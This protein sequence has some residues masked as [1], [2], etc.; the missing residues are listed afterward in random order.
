M[1][2]ATLFWW[3][4]PVDAACAV[5]FLPCRHLRAFRP[6]RFKVTLEAVLVLEGMALRCAAR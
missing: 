5:G 6:D 2:L 1:M 3:D 4:L